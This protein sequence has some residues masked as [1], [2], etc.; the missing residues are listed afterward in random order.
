VDE[1]QMQTVEELL[2]EATKV[3]PKKGEDRAGYLVRIIEAC[4]DLEDTLWEGLPEEAQLW[5]NA[6]A[7][8]LKANKSPDDFPAEEEEA[9]EP[10]EGEGEPA[11]AETETEGEEEQEE[12]PAAAKPAKKVV[13]KPSG[14]KK[15]SAQIVIRELVLEN[16]KIS[17]GDLNTKLA[18]QGYTVSMSTI[19]TTKAA[20]TQSVRVLQEAN[21]LKRKIL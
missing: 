6:G 14:E 8:K 11:E 3:T 15:K 13:K 12:K 5:V 2:Q 7:K 16:P 1:E 18:S 20:F 9:E 21:M 4:Q 19:T 10:E 17:A